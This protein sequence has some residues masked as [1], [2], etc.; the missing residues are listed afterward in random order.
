MVINK[1]LCD[2]LRSRV[3]LSICEL[4]NTHF[5]ANDTFKLNITVNAVP[6]TPQMTPWYPGWIKPFRPGLYIRRNRIGYTAMQYWNGDNWFC[7]YGRPADCSVLAS[8]Q[9]TLEWRGLAERGLP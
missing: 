6:A 9:D 8:F 1:L 3:E 7:Y 4:Q 5:K 2:T